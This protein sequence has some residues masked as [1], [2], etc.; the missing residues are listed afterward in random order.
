MNG[1]R[2]NATVLSYEQ[3]VAAIAARCRPLGVERVPLAKG[4]GRFLAAD[5]VASIPSPPFDNSAVD[6]YA[7]G[8]GKSPYKVTGEVAA[9]SI[10]TQRLGR[11]EAV[12]IFTG[13]PVPL[14]TVAIA[15]IEDCLE[16]GG[17]VDVHES[18]QHTRR[19]GEDYDAGSMIA[20]TGDLLTPPMIGLLASA[21]VY[22]VQVPRKPRVALITTGDETRPLG[23]VLEAGQIYD[24]NAVALA[25][26]LQAIGLEPRHLHLR[27]DPGEIANSVD[28][29]VKESE[30]VLTCGGV[31]VGARDHLK[32]SFAECGVEEVF[33]RVSIKPGKPIYFGTKGHTLVFGLPG[34]P[35][36]ALMTFYLFAR[37]ALLTAMGASDPWPKPIIATLSGSLTKA[38]DRTEFV[39]ARL[40]QADGSAKVVA[41]TGQESHMFLGTSSADCLIVFPAHLGRLE[42]GSVVEVISVRWGLV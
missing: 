37:P 16:A 1:I 4:L 31:S 3:A 17:A 14:G 19:R 22:E 42:S 13:A 33:W 6:G 9:G 12:R 36:S 38:Q 20:R 24:S 11:G 30:I 15:M 29:A 8:P 26:A 28:M 40:R 10:L 21:G 35:I 27:D 41:T 5:Q 32:S 39:R 25:A 2:H 34:N 23:S 7:L 18:G